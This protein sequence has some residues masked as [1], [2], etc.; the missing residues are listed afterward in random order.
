[1]LKDEHIIFNTT[2]SLLPL[3]R[4]PMACAILFWFFSV[5]RCGQALT[6]AP[7]LAPCALSH[8][9]FNICPVGLYLSRPFSTRRCSLKVPAPRCSA[10]APKTALIS[11]GSSAVIVGVTIKQRPVPRRW[12]LSTIKGSDGRNVT[13]WLRD[14]SRKDIQHLQ[15]RKE[16]N[17]AGIKREKSVC[18]KQREVIG[19]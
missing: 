3:F 7:S 14:I 5:Q 16:V 18:S 4:S 6:V 15:E 10:V 13:L 2:K 8:S 9:V 11:R 12:N 19:A 1:M 17:N